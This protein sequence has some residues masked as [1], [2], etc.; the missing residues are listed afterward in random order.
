VLGFFP[1]DPLGMSSEEMKLKEVKNGRL[2]MIALVGFCSQA[3]VQGM[4]PID[5][6]KAHIADPTHANV[7]TSKVAPEFTFAVVCL[8]LAPMVIEAR[9]SVAGSDEDQFKPIPW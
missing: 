3:A 6:L 2:A 5:C 1:F 9:K 7:Y 8:T 4:G